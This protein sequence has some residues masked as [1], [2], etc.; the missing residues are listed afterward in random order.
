MPRLTMEAFDIFEFQKNVGLVIMTTLLFNIY[1]S[2]YIA[3]FMT[4][5]H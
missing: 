4:N 3:M 5:I 2:E 1:A